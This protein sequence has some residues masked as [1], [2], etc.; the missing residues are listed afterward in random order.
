MSR[1]RIF[2]IGPIHFGGYAEPGPEDDPVEWLQSAERR[3]QIDQFIGFGI[4]LA[5]LTAVAI[6][7]HSSR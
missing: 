6:L 4:V 2:N 7:A 5:I 1:K 3:R